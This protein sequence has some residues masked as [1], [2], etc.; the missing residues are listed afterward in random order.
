MYFA[1]FSAQTNLKQLK[2]IRYICSV[3]IRWEK[4]K[5]PK[6]ISQCY[7]CQDF[8]HGTDYCHRKPRCVKCTKQHLTKDCDKPAEAKPQCVNCSGDHPANASEC[9]TYKQ[10]LQKVEGRRQ[11]AVAAK[12]RVIQLPPEPVNN[13]S[14]PPLRERAETQVP[15][16]VNADPRLRPRQSQ[17]SYHSSHTHDDETHSEK[18]IGISSPGELLANTEATATFSS[19]VQEI[20]TLQTHCDLNKMLEMLKELNGKLANCSDHVTQC[21]IFYNVI[22]KYV[23]K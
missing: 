2:A 5:N 19:I 20:K 3:K 18:Q 12:Q 4:Y 23:S 15:K 8:N 13:R 1:S 16:Q 14:Y 22:L 6:K 9:P 10:H 21:S 11:A 17:S 7:R